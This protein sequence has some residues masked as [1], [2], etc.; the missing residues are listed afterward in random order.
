MSVVVGI[1][2]ERSIGVSRYCDRLAASLQALGLEYVVAATP[3]RGHAAHWHLAN[4]SRGAAWQAPRRRAPFAVTVHDVV[5]RTTALMPFYRLVVYPVVRRAAAV[6]VHSRYAADVLRETAG[7]A[8]KVH[9]IPHP[10]ARP[11]KSDRA[12]ARRALGWPEDARIA[13]LPG[14]IKA[15]KL[16]GV[17]VSGVRGAAGWRLALAGRV[18]DAAA[19][20]AARAAGAFVLESPDEETYERAI[21]AADAV[22]VLRSASVGET[23]GPLLDALGAGRAMIATATGSIP[24]VAGEAALLCQPTADAVRA[25]LERLT[26][27]EERHEREL[28]AAARG[29]ELTWAASAE[30]HA[31][32]FEQ[33]F[34]A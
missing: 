33:V 12:D 26:D 20:A 16:I 22:V 10:A 11:A 9:V 25:A 29:A 27:E 30:S 4:S 2:A 14:V 15:A 21:V 8:A 31:S 18:Q 1:R 28:L 7:A 32:L 24:E 19:A 23:N 6:V 17:A 5:P 3:R 13:V 34:G